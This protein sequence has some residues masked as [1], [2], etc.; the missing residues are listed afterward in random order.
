M[1]L[2]IAYL[3]SRYPSISHTFIHREIVGLRDLG[4]EVHTYSVRP[5]QASDALT[6]DDRAEQ[7]Q[8]AALVP[9]GLLPGARA[10]LLAARHPLA[11]LELART[12]VA[13]RRPRSLRRAAYAAEALVLSAHL[14]ARRVEHVHAH[15]A[16]VASDVAALAAQFG[17]R[18]GHPIRWTFTMHGPTEFGHLDW[19]GVAW[20]VERADRVLCISDFCRSQL[21]ALVP[22]THWDK[23]R[24]VHCGVPASRFTIP[25]RTSAPNALRI[26]CVGRLV[27][28]KAQRLLVAAVGQLR[29]RGI[30]ASLVLVGA[31]PDRAHLEA[32]VDER[33]L[34]THVRFTGAVGQDEI[35]EHYRDADAFCLP[36]FGEGVPVVLMEAMATGLP[37]V[38]TRI[39]GIAELVEHGVSGHVVAPGRVDVLVDALTELAGDPER[40]HAMGQAGRAKVLAEFES[41]KVAEQ[42]YAE[43][44]AVPASD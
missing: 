3:T 42:V 31:G 33:G 21:M 36:S 39:A 28:E 43:L 2:R 8:T 41:A 44:S 29:E 30:D 11:A 34:R 9:P 18:T 5:T 37:V 26:V 12:A 7:S 14:R 32:A 1:T 17:R 27:P 25:E 22:A 38:T 23:L 15:F 13:G 19:F 16:N 40:R 10:A 24:V 6:D 4:A 35:F 20:K